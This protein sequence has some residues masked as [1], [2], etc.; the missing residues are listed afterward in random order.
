MSI[1]YQF[2]VSRYT[3][4]YFPCHPRMLHKSRLT[5]LTMQNRQNV[6]FGKAAWAAKPRTR[7]PA[8][9]LGEPRNVENTREGRTR[10]T[11]VTNGQARSSMALTPTLFS[12]R[13]QRRIPGSRGS[14]HVSGR[15]TVGFQH[16]FDTA[17]GNDLESDSSPHCMRIVHGDQCEIRDPAIA[18]DTEGSLSECPGGPPSTGG[19]QHDHVVDEN[20]VW[21]IG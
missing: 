5:G 8:V 4:W 2:N 19:W 12:L 18:P 20:A 11:N 16:F 6:R 13:L 17:V 10:S 14:D 7:F 3:T 15:G 1:R 9:S 21:R